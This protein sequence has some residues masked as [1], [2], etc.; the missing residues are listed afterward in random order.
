MVEGILSKKSGVEDFKPLLPLVQHRVNGMLK[1]ANIQTIAN[2]CEVKLRTEEIISQD[3]TVI[4]NKE[5][6]GFHFKDE[7]ELTQSMNINELK[8][9][10]LSIPRL[11]KKTKEI[12]TNFGTAEMSYLVRIAKSE[13]KATLY[14]ELTQIGLGRKLKV[15][16]SEIISSY[17]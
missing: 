10:I 16:V 8:R 15:Q 11:S 4:L 7:K 6:Q 5:V 17:Q 13:P 1:F 12:I 2:K 14:N 9:E 3:K